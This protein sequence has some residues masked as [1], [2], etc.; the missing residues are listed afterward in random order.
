MATIETNAGEVSRLMQRLFRDQ[1]P[2]ALA[3]AINDVAKQSQSNQRAR[4]RRIFEVRNRRFIDSSVKLKPFATKRSPEAVLRVEPLGGAE[5]AS[6]ISQHE[7]QVRKVPRDGRN[8]AVPSP[9]LMG[10]RRQRG[11]PKDLRPAALQ[12][13]E[14]HPNMAQ[15]ENR[16]FR[17]TTNGGRNA[18]LILQ[19]TGRG[20]R[21]RT[22]VLY[23]LRPLARLRPELLFVRTISDTVR[24]QFPRA[25]GR[26]FD[27]AV[28][29]AK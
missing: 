24:N 9:Y 15:G 3:T 14:R 18:G 17:V 27:H 8:L 6:I 13:K 11:V 2:F 28:R 29:T 21:S 16:T 7:D 1:M 25:M 20:R 22:R 4:Q 5:R 26:A 12:L 19:R 10:R 23:F